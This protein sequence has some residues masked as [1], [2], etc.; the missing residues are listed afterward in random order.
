[1]EFN[2]W[3]Y[4]TYLYKDKVLSIWYDGVKD[5]EKA[6]SGNVVSNTG[7]FY[8]GRNPWYN[9]LDGAEYDNL[10]MHRAALTDEEIAQTATGAIVFNED[11]VLAY[12]FGDRADG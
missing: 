10:Q 7:N 4:V 8:F 12:D 1:M 11:L 2:Q 6:I 3:Y 9:G 5:S